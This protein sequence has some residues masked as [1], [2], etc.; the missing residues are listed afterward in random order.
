MTFV[1][2]DSFRRPRESSKKS[3]SI[4]GEIFDLIIYD[5]KIIFLSNKKI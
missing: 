3:H 2:G 5:S 1:F 4:L